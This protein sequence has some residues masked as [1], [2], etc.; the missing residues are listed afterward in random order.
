MPQPMP[1][2][3]LLVL[4]QNMHTHVPLLTLAVL[5]VW[6]LQCPNLCL[7]PCCLYFFKTCTHMCH[8]LY[9]LKTCTH[10]C[11][12]LLTPAA[13]GSA[14]SRQCR[15]RGRGWQGRQWWGGWTRGWQ[16]GRAVFWYTSTKGSQAAEQAVGLEADQ[17][18]NYTITQTHSENQDDFQKHIHP[19]NVRLIDGIHQVPGC[20]MRNCSNY[21]P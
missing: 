5:T 20:C 2:A 10:M 9:F 14:Q 4:F 1:L 18:S 7:W 16:R 11:H 17:V 13:G 6:F 3:L 21:S 12:S 19:C 15:G 8:C